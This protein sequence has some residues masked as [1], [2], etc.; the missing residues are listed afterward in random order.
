MPSLPVNFNLNYK[1]SAPGVARGPSLLMRVNPILF[2]LS[3]HNAVFEYL[4]ECISR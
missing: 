3:T 2:S 1:D 4:K